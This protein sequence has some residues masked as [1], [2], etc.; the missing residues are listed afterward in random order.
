MD[1]INGTKLSAAWGAKYHLH[2]DGTVT[3]DFTIS[4]AQG[5][6]PGYAHGGALAAL[7]DEAMGAANWFAG[8]RGMSVHLSFDYKQPVP[9]GARI[10]VSGKVERREGRKVFTIGTV[11][12]ENGTVAVNGSGI[13]VDTPQLLENTT[14]FTLEK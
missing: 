8:N 3:A 13:F 9:L 4:D 10:H 7:I 5:G 14:G 2:A 12:L 6:P 1:A 11:A